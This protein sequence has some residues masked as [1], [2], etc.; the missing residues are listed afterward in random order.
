[1]L[2]LIRITSGENNSAFYIGKKTKMKFNFATAH[3]DLLIYYSD[4]YIYV[5][6]T[7]TNK[8]VL[9]IHYTLPNKAYQSLEANTYKLIVLQISKHPIF[10]TELIIR[11]WKAHEIV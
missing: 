5:N 2:H 6:I 10:I 4:K 11:I 9:I 8:Y 3:D 7:H 1:M